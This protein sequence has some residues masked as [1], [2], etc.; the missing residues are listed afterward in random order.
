MGVNYIYLPTHGEE[1]R[2]SGV[3]IEEFI[4]DFTSTSSMSTMQ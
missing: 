1:S 4:L 3:K 2:G